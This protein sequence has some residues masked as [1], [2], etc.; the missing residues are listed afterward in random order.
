MEGARNSGRI[1][2]G[3]NILPGGSSEQS[4]IRPRFESDRHMDAHNPLGA[5]PNSD[6]DYFA[7]G[8]A[9][10]NTTSVAQGNAN[11]GPSSSTVRAPH[12]RA[13]DDKP[14]KPKFTVFKDADVVEE[15]IDEMNA[16]H[17]WAEDSFE[18]RDFERAVV[19]ETP[20]A[21][22]RF[23]NAMD[24]QRL[25]RHSVNN[26]ATAATDAPSDG[27]V[28][29]DQAGDAI[30]NRDSAQGN[31]SEGNG[32]FRSKI[33]VEHCAASADAPADEE[34]FI[35][36]SISEYRKSKSGSK[37]EKE[38]PRA[39]GTNARRAKA[40]PATHVVRDEPQAAQPIVNTT[41]DAGP[42]TRA[43]TNAVEPSG[44][45]V[46]SAAAAQSVAPAAS[47]VLT[48][49]SGVRVP[50]RVQP[51]RVARAKAAA[52][53]KHDT[54]RKRKGKA[55][56]SA[57]SPEPIQVKR[58][59]ALAT[60][61]REESVALLRTPR[62]TREK[63]KAPAPP[64]SAPEPPAKPVRTTRQRAPVARAVPAPAPPTKAV[65]ATRKKAPV[66]PPAPA[67][68]KPVR[69]TR[70]KAEPAPV[71]PPPPPAPPAEPA[72]PTKTRTLRSK[73]TYGLEVPQPK[74]R[75]RRTALQAN[76]P[77]PKWRG[78]ETAGQKR[79]RDDDDAATADDDDAE[80]PGPSKRRKPARPYVVMPTVN[81]SPEQ[82]ALF[83]AVNAA[84]PVPRPLRRHETTLVDGELYRR[85]Q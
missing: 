38:G 17:Y 3:W 80:A 34:T 61:K 67:P 82:Q 32:A 62:K 77:A 49:P 25:S 59:R 65:R 45:T 74:P 22:E 18:F 28:Y 51:A 48:I 12:Q 23:R 85:D 50:T 76:P 71:A 66:A 26:E 36:D 33:H 72:D 75:T 15:E 1:I 78:E 29:V 63:A 4:T 9:T 20:V 27:S 44:S 54:T 57:P 19:A 56:A 11:A 84:P 24:A 58:R 7:A 2:P 70:Q 55:R 43:S 46:G 16:G 39:K 13:Q 68:A 73:R 35:G 52:L 5:D 6:D 60:I 40:G 10:F 53:A 31:I 42:S 37:A 14:A 8:P 64:P 47:T 21:S 69:K 79:R 83:D 30:A 41:E 81:L